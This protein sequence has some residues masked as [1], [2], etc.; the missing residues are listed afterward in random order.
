VP[1]SQINLDSLSVED[2]SH[3]I[4]EAEAKRTEKQEGAKAALIEEMT[5]K[6]AELG[7]SLDALLG[8]QAQSKTNVRK[9]RGNKGQQV[10]AKFRNPEGETWSGRGRMPRWLTKSIDEGKSKEDFAV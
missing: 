4:Q 10:A 2:P 6:A 9:V 3:L 5:V 1:K 8:N 7:L